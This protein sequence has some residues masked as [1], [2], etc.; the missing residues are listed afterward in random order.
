VPTDRK[1]TQNPVITGTLLCL[2]SEGQIW[3]KVV[4]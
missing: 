2:Y 3:A 4:L 1:I